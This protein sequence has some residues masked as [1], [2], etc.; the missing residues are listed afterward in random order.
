M[1][2]LFE[3]YEQ[4]I[5]LIDEWDKSLTE[6]ANTQ[7][8]ADMINEEFYARKK[9]EKELII[10]YHQYFLSLHEEITRSS[11]S[12]QASALF[13]QL[14]SEKNNRLQ[15]SSDAQITHKN[16]LQQFQFITEALKQ[17]KLITDEQKAEFKQIDDQK[18]N[19]EWV[20]V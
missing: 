12:Y 13:K 6:Y 20:L 17:R 9:I 16:T 19:N 10:S 2:F 15:I 4:I 18:K 14:E 3:L 8:R 7:D 5:T 11:I 1:R